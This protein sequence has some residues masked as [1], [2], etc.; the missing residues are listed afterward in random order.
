MFNPTPAEAAGAHTIW[1]PEEI[2]GAIDYYE[3]PRADLV[4][5]PPSWS[6]LSNQLNIRGITARDLEEGGL[7]VQNQRRGVDLHSDYTDEHYK[8]VVKLS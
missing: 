3:I 7:L 4:Y 5:N 1:G 8:G 6:A 2:E